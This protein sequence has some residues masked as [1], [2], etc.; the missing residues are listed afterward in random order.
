MDKHEAMFYKSR[1]DNK[2]KCQL[3]AHNCLVKPGQSG[4]CNVRLNE[5]GKLYSL[6]YGFP[7]TENI[8]PI[9]KKP[10]F[11]FQ[12]GTLSYSI[13]TAGCNFRCEHCQNYSISQLPLI[14]RS[15]RG[16]KS[17]PE[18]IVQRAIDSG[19]SSIAYTYTEPTIFYEFALDIA[20][21]ATESG[22]KN[23]FV[24]N[25]YINPEPLKKIK[26]YLHGAN[27]DLKSF[28]DDFYRKICKAKLQPVLD[29]IKLYYQMNIW[30][31]ITT[32]VIPSL[33]DSAEELNKIAE[34]IAGIDRNI[35]WHVSAFFPTYKMI[36]KEPTSPQILMQAREIGL[37]KGL[38]FVYTGN[39]PGQDGEK[40]FCPSCGKEIISRSGYSISNIEIDEGKC[41]YCGH[42][43]FGIWD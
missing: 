29:S 9:E 31:E 24:T 37:Q 27:I 5:N 4:V 25:G 23:I 17:S 32:L 6:I 35:P 12:P 18:Q 10:L 42:K 2:V 28:S 34:F 21:L 30:I 1:Q 33:N 16:Q 7:I 22:L 20:V 14:E 39:I 3:C 11:H 40:T 8:D 26:P 36:D 41:K 19:C 15:I 13:A 38:K 43:I